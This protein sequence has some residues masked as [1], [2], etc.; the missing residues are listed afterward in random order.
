[1]PHACPLLGSN[2]AKDIE[3]TVREF[4]SYLILRNKHV[5]F[6]INARDCKDDIGEHNVFVQRGQVRD[7][8]KIFSY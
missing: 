6:Y 7:I 8:G 4:L 3:H 1:M 5:G 2:C